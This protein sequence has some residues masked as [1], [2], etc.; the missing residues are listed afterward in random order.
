LSTYAKDLLLRVGAVFA[1]TF[2]STYSFAD[3]SNPK[4]ALISGAAAAAEVIRGLLG[5]FVGDPN[6]AG[7]HS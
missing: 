1:F 4:T 5:K 7:F 3:L 6:S 2:L